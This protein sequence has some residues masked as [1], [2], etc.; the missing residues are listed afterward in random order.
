MEKLDILMLGDTRAHWDFVDKLIQFEIEDMQRTY[1]YVLYTGGQG[2]QEQVDKIEHEDPETEKLAHADHNK[3]MD[4]LYKLLKKN[5]KSKLIY[6]PGG[7]DAPFLYDHDEHD[8]HT[9]A[10]NLHK[11]IYELAESLH[12]VGIGGSVPSVLETYSED[13]DMV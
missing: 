8:E 13:G 10:V 3:T 7:T 5:D 1:D 4:K 2:A 11:N 12:V 6:V 9:R